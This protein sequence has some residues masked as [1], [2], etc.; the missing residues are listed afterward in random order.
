MSGS[1]RGKKA[2]EEAAGEGHARGDKGPNLRQCQRGEA[3][4]HVREPW[5]GEM[6]ACRIW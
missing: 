1:S 2:M 4:L 6:R 5:E 3:G